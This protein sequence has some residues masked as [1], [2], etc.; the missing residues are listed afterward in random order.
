MGITTGLTQ[1]WFKSKRCNILKGMQGNVTPGYTTRDLVA[2]QIKREEGKDQTDL[3]LCSAYFPSDSAEMP[4]L[5]EFKEMVQYGSKKKL[6]LLV[7]SDANTHH[8]VWN[9]SVSTKGGR[10]YA[11]PQGAGSTS[12]KQMKGT[13]IN[14]EGET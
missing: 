7:G 8:T 13:M 1:R 6:E 9:R 4:P 3:V 5:I 2:V 11:I 14:Y 10:V 12:P